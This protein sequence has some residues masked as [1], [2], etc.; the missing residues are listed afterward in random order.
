[1][2]S[3]SVVDI[4][5]IL[6]TPCTTAEERAEICVHAYDGLQTILRDQCSSDYLVDFFDQLCQWRK[7]RVSALL[8]EKNVPPLWVTTSIIIEAMLRL[9][10]FDLACT[11]GASWA[12]LVRVADRVAEQERDAIETAR[13][14][15]IETDA[16]IIREHIYKMAAYEH[17]NSETEKSFDDIGALGCA[18]IICFPYTKAEDDW[19]TNNRPSFNTLRLFERWSTLNA[20]AAML[21]NALEKH[22]DERA[23][24]HV[25]EHVPLVLQWARKW[26][27]DLADPHRDLL[28]ERLMRALPGNNA[29]TVLDEATPNFWDSPDKEGAEARMRPYAFFLNISRPDVAGETM[30]QARESVKTVWDDEETSALLEAAAI[31]SLHYAIQQLCDVKIMNRFVFDDATPMDTLEH[32]F[33]FANEKNSLRY[34]PRLIKS[35]GSWFVVVPESQIGPRYTCAKAHNWADAVA[36]WCVVL[37]NGMANGMVARGKCA[38]NTILSILGQ[39]AQNRPKDPLRAALAGNI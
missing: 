34:V 22:E 17:W 10:T 23:A 2:A 20:A 29:C 21:R 26:K 19:I 3:T 18:S 33:S 8:H 24:P 38:N 7:N 27:G 39:T 32:I 13:L 9:I 31:A 6:S 5:S 12:G 28:T 36:R 16:P 30:K 4:F 37:K 15:G 1:M 25:P 14:S 35:R 11:A